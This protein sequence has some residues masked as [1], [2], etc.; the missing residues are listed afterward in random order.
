MDEV[1]Y[2]GKKRSLR[3]I[4]TERLQK[5]SA[6]AL[7]GVLNAVRACEGAVR[8]SGYCDICHDQCHD[9]TSADKKRLSAIQIYKQE[10]KNI[11]ATKPHVE[12]KSK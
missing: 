9:L 8:N 2:E 12:R 10:I 3:R 4:S 5:M 7:K 11:L 1:L 6:R